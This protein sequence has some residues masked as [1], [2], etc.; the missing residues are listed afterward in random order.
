MPK[1]C[2]ASGCGCIRLALLNQLV[3]TVAE[4]RMLPR[5]E[6]QSAVMGRVL[7]ANGL[8]GQPPPPPPP[9]AP[10]AVAKQQGQEGQPQLQQRQTQARAQQEGRK[11]S[12]FD[13]IQHDDDE[14]LQPLPRPAGGPLPGVG[15]D[16]EGQRIY[17]RLKASV[18]SGHLEGTSE[19]HRSGRHAPPQA[20]PPM[21]SGNLVRM[22]RRLAEASAL[23]RRF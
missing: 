7:E 14:A 12:L 3:E 15:A 11:P 18:A 10:K 23:G 19:C 6:L 5:S 20:E 4:Q 17:S 22:Q 16:E 13:L 21:C 8:A 2:P 1:D 9:P